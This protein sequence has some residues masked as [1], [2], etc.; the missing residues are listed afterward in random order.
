MFNV[1][2]GLFEGLPVEIFRMIQIL[3][4]NVHHFEDIDYLCLMKTN[5]RMFSDIKYSTV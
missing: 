5:K 3:L 4:A 1:T 2:M